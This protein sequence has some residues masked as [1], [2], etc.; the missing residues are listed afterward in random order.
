MG[1]RRFD[2]LGSGSSVPATVGSYKCCTVVQCSA[3]PCRWEFPSP[4]RSL[5]HDNNANSNSSSC[6]VTLSG[7]LGKCK[8]AT[9]ANTLS[10][11][12]LRQLDTYRHDNTEKSF[13]HRRH[14]S[15]VRV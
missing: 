10:N 1:I 15:W 12:C 9:A 7:V 8:A 3:I 5:L 11:P 4:N 14:S 2:S 13:T 6:R